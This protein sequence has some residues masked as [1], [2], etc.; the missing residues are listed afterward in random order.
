MAPLCSISK[1]AHLLRRTFPLLKT[2]CAEFVSWV[3]ER[4]IERRRERKLKTT[5]K[6][7]TKEEREGE[8]TRFPIRIPVFFSRFHSPLLSFF[9]NWKNIFAKY[10]GE[11]MGKNIIK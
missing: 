1:V 6:E 4:E 9:P 8:T 5:R 7:E 11:T 2:L 10:P 3:E